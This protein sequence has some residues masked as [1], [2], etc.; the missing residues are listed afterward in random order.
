MSNL[1]KKAE[2]KV[3]VF[4]I[5]LIGIAS[6]ILIWASAGGAAGVIT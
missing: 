3:N 6:A 5:I 4:G 2:D 1:P